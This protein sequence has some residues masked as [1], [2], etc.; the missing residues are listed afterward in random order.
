MGSIH[1]SGRSPGVG[2]GNPVQYSCLGSLVNRKA[3]RAIVCGAAKRRTQLNDWAYLCTLR[4]K[5]ITLLP[6]SKGRT[7]NIP[8]LVGL[9]KPNCKPRG[10]RIDCVKHLA[11]PEGGPGLPAPR[12]HNQPQESWWRTIPL[13]E[14]RIKQSGLESSRAYLQIMGQRHLLQ[15]SNHEQ[16]SPARSFYLFI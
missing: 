11:S 15:K 10:N 14:G 16:I 1:G 8:S 13:C 9:Q 7:E 2:K 12:R 3:W 5:H 4:C 6:G